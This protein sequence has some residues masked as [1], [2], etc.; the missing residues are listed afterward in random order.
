[1]RSVK[2]TTFSQGSGVGV[3]PLRLANRQ[4]TY[5]EDVEHS[6]LLSHAAGHRCVADRDEISQCL[7]FDQQSGPSRYR[8]MHLSLIAHPTFHADSALSGK[9][10]S[11]WGTLGTHQLARRNLLRAIPPTRGHK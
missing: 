4:L 3:M 6:S 7:T 9:R 5:K 2:G 10:R 11:C 1:M 8:P